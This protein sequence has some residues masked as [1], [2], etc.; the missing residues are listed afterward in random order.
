MTII[1]AWVHHF[2][3]CRNCERERIGKCTNIPGPCTHVL[4]L[5]AFLEKVDTATSGTNHITALRLRRRAHAAP[6]ISGSRGR[7]YGRTR[8]CE[9][10]TP[11]RAS[12][13][14][15][16]EATLAKRARRPAHQRRQRRQGRRQRSYSAAKSARLPAHQRR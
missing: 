13:A 4:F 2:M 5:K 6:R 14:A 12:A 3:N 10:R 7:G 15:G 9:E 16:A 8:Y 1:P 11:P